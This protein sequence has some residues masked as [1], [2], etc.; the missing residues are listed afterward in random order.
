MLINWIEWSKGTLA[1]VKNTQYPA[2]NRL[3]CFIALLLSVSSAA[4]A[5]WAEVNGHR[6]FYEVRG[7]GKPVLVLHGGGSTADESFAP[8]FKD[9]KTRFQFIAPEQVGHGH[10][11]DVEG[12]FSY[13][14][15]ADDTAELLKSLKLGKVDV[16]G[17]SDG[18]IIALIL[19]NRYPDLVNRLIVSGANYSPEGLPEKDLRELEEAAPEK[20]LGDKDHETYRAESPDGDSHFDAVCEKLRQLWLHHP[21]PDELSVEDLHQ[22]QSRVLV[23]SGDHDAVRLSHTLQIYKTLP[24]AELLVLPATG[25]DTFNEKP[26]YVEQEIVRFLTEP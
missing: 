3:L 22:I 20:L 18:G 14:S 8:L 2:M 5:K 17:W 21:S 24:N 26:E 12:P 13:V 9:L 1:A 10:T 15:M 6:L 11:P 23:M 19:G 16:I 4:Q 7:S 25:H